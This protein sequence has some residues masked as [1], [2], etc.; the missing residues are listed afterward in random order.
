MLFVQ[1]AAAVG[2]AAGSNLGVLSTV[3]CPID[4]LVDATGK[5]MYNILFY[6]SEPFFVGA[7]AENIR[8]HLLEA[9]ATLRA[10]HVL[11]V[12][13][14]L[15]G[16]RPCGAVHLKSRQMLTFCSDNPTV[17][18]SLRL[19]V[20][21]S[22]MALFECGCATHAANLVGKDFSAIEPFQ[23]SRIN[24]VIIV[25]P[26]TR[27]TR[28]M[29]LL[30][31]SV[32]KLRMAGEHMTYFETYSRTRWVGETASIASVVG[33]ISTLRSTLS[34]K[35]HV[36]KRVAIHAAVTVA[37]NEPGPHAGVER[38]LPFLRMISM[39]TATIEV[40]R[41]PL[42]TVAGLLSALRLCL[43]S[44]FSE[45]LL[46]TRSSCHTDVD[47]RWV[48]INSSSDAG[49]R[50]VLRCVFGGGAHAGCCFGVEWQ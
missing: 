5:V 36:R 17:V 14:S 25:V 50:H 23:A 30:L 45:L 34:D 37:V 10:A 22:D 42:S 41:A 32:Q 19:L 28:G 38:A 31:A 3:R 40:D 26:L 21:V 24:A 1:S 48:E 6:I 43:S 49:A 9:P 8:S 39:C 46:A 2:A 47:G 13:F 16:A 35:F 33:S 20:A 44:C 27:S 11:R 4:G 15:G 7:T 18:H 12:G 29:T